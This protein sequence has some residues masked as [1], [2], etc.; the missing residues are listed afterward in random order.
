MT[1]S[2][3]SGG[4]AN[5]RWLRPWRDILEHR[6]R[7]R[8]SWGP[9]PRSRSCRRSSP[10]PPDPCLFQVTSES[11]Q[12]DFVP[13]VT[14]HRHPSALVAVMELSMT[15]PLV[16]DG[17]TVILQQSDEPLTLTFSHKPGF[18]Q[19]CTKRLMERVDWHS[20]RPRRHWLTHRRTLVLRFRQ[21]EHRMFAT[22]GARA[23]AGVGRW[24]RAS[25]AG[26]NGSNRSCPRCDCD[27]RL[28]WGVKVKL[29]WSHP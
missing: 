29:E 17:P 18:A 21:A 27:D 25:C 3:S 12:K 1:Q 13:Q 28:H 7:T 26:G 19:L 20:T 24:A 8:R 6:V 14:R 11:S 9:R 4:L 16:S 10:G 23:L 5:V 2:S 15:S 22:A